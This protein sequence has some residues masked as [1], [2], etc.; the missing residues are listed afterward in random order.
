MAWT[1]VAGAATGALLSGSMGG[2]GATQTTTAD[3]SPWAPAAPWMQQNIDRGQQ[4]QKFYQ[5]NPFSNAQKQAYGNQ[6]ALNDSYNQMLPQLM[7]GLNQPGFNRANP[8]ARPTPQNFTPPTAMN[9]G[10]MGS[11]NPFSQGAPSTPVPSVNPN[12]AALD[13]MAADLARQSN[14]SYG[15]DSSTGN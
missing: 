8:T 6:F 12:Q 9:L 1:A 3:K 13:R 4:L 14:F 2:R 15:A 5:D 7:A 11:T 10:L